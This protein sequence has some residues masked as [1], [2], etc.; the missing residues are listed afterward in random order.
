MLLKTSFGNML[1]KF[2]FTFICIVLIWYLCLFRTSSMRIGMFD[3][4]DKWV[5]ITMYLGSC[6]VFWVEYF[7]SGLHWERTRQLLLA[8]LLP[9]A[10]SGLV[11]LAQD[12]LTTYRSADWLDFAANSLGV[13]LALAARPLWRKL[14]R[15]L[16]G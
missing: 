12:K 14:A 11:E 3:G 16:K 6:A 4:F 8:V 1:R 2:P 13:A 15:K 9:I 5:H 7:R 10:M